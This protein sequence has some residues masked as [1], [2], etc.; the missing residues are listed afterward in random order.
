MYDT[1]SDDYDRFVN[2]PAR[3]AAEIPFIVQ[4]LDTIRNSSGRPLNV[5]DTACGTGMHVIAL[6]QQGYSVAGADL[7]TG[8]IEKARSN[9]TAAGVDIDFKVAGFGKLAEA[10]PNGNS[11]DALLCLGNSLPHLLTPGALAATLVDFAACLRSGGLVMI[12]NRNFDA[13]LVHK[14]RWMEPQTHQEGEAEW[15]FLRFYDFEAGGLLTF[16]VIT[17]HRHAGGAWTQEAVATRLRPPLQ[18]ELVG[19]MQTAGFENIAC[20]GS[21]SATPFD[22]QTSGNLVVT[23]RKGIPSI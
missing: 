19:A 15:V 9:A 12:Q 10:F 4:Q 13:V 6:A 1:F 7:S 23:A 3:L 8:M 22:P 18:D 17:L 14:E 11:F 16:N 2:W 20:Y 21:M 5:L